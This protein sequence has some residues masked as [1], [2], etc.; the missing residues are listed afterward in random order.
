LIGGRHRAR[1]SPQF[2]SED[3]TRQPQRAHSPASHFSHR[4][5]LWTHCGDGN[6]S[7]SNGMASMAP[8]TLSVVPKKNQQID[9]DNSDLSAFVGRGR[10]WVFGELVPAAGIARRAVALSQ[11]DLEC[12]A[13]GV[14]QFSVASG[15]VALTA[16]ADDPVA[17][18][19]ELDDIALVRLA[20]LALRE[21]CTGRRPDS[22][23][24]PGHG[25]RR[26]SRACAG[27]LLLGVPIH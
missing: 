15:L 19:C 27:A 21:A 26:R 22:A 6:R 10:Q 8:E 11:R 23:R 2:C 7:T 25:R 13:H 16:G 14:H 12:H 24:S 17:F 4:A 5:G 20:E 3:R 9:C 1:H 18:F